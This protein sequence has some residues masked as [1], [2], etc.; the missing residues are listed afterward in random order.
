MSKLRV[1]ELCKLK[2]MS[3]QDIATALH[4]NRVNLSNSL[5]GNPTLDRLRQVAEVLGVEV[6]E[7]FQTP[8]VNE[9]SGFVEFQGEIF[10]INTPEDLFNLTDKVRQQITPL[11]PG[12]E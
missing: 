4:I 12:K 8:R 2:G 6:P 10:K 11:A 9:L 3:M 7:L 1:K 5:N